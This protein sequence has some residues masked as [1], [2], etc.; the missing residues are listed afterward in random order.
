MKRIETKKNTESAFYH[1]E[2]TVP[3]KHFPALCVTVDLSHIREPN[4]RNINFRTQQA[5]AMLSNSP[6]FLHGKH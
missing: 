4:Q 1:R 3:L 2:N 5:Y 6:I